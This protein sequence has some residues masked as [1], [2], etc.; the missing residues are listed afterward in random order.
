MKLCTVQGCSKTFL[1]K[2]YC[3]MHYSR[4]KRTGSALSV[5][6][7]E[8]RPSIKDGEN[9]L[10]PLGINARKGYAVVDE[11]FKFLE[12]YNWSL[13][14]RDCPM[15]YIDGKVQNLHHIVAGKPPKG[16]VTDHINRNKL[17]ARKL[18]LRH[19]TSKENSNNVDWSFR[20][21]KSNA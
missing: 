15:A 21:A 14:A 17:D 9:I 8:K 11:E 19:I 5:T 6:T 10:L 12:K 4:L 7:K 16:L 13:G 1:A 3:H 2:G 20:L 18:N